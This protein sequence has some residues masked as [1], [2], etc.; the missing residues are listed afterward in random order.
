M[1]TM[2]VGKFIGPRPNID[3]VVFFAKN[4]WNLK[5][6]VEVLAIAKGFMSFEFSCP[7]DYENILCTRN[8][9]VGR[10]SLILQKWTSNLDLNNYFLVQAQV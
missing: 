10:S 5:G 6:Q 2:L 9:S 3:V 1:A 7:K 8:W 4:K